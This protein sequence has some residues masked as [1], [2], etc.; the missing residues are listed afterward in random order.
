MNVTGFIFN[1]IFIYKF[2]IIINIVLLTKISINIYCNFQKQKKKE[3]F[4]IR[5][6]SLKKKIR[7][8]EKSGV[9]K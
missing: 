6:S 8:I 3:V 2:P 7:L 4:L 1:M 5:I 9:T